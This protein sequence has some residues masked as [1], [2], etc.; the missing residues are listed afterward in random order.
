MWTGVILCLAAALSVAFI[1]VH[2]RQRGQIQ[3]LETARAKIQLEEKRV[4]DFLH[5]LGEALSEDAR[6]D[7]LHRLIVEY[8]T[9]T[10]DIN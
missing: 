1:I 8:L 6:P 9:S 7:D 4:F 10:T 5:G 2:R 3:A